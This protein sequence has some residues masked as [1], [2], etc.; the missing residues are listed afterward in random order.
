MINLRP[1]ATIGLLANGRDQ[2]TLTLWNYSVDTG[3]IPKPEVRSTLLTQTI[4]CCK[5]VYDY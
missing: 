2:Q 5:H 4:L 3:C 1:A